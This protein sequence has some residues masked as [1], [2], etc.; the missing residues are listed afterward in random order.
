MKEAEIRMWSQIMM[1]LGWESGVVP[2]LDTD[3]DPAEKGTRNDFANTRPAANQM[4]QENQKLFWGTDSRHIPCWEKDIHL[5][6]TGG[7]TETK[8]WSGLGPILGWSPCSEQ[9]LIRK[10]TL[11][12]IKYVHKP[13]VDTVNHGH[14]P[15]QYMPLV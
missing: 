11:V 1:G 12:T 13:H 3:K 15:E 7:W 6:E 8:M 5:S 4:L 10:G 9:D 14:C 2:I